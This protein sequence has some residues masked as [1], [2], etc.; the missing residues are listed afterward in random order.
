[1]LN[2]TVRSVEE[3]LI[4]TATDPQLSDILKDYA[5]LGVDS[6]LDSEV[7][8]AIPVVKSISALA[9]GVATIQDRIFLKK[10]AHFLSTANNLTEGERKAWHQ[11][12][13][14]GSRKIEAA[15]GGKLMTMVDAV[16]DDYKAA[17][18]GKL[19][20]AF[21]KDDIKT[22]DHFYYMTELVEN[23]FTSILKALAQGTDVNDE[24]LFRAGIKHTS[25]PSGRDI[26]EML[27]RDTRLGG[28]GLTTTSQLPYKSA[29]YTPAGVLLIKILRGN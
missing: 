19:F 20:Y 27:E 22:I 15:I 23:C 4:G 21:V 25:A 16:N 2:R 8:E 18:L 5:E 3:N 14:Q 10:L 12:H 9:K 1:M 26:Q 17:V 6:I 28:K 11:K 29:E 13:I 24:A 7:I